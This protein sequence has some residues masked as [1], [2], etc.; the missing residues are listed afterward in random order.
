MQTENGAT[1]V[2]GTTTK[3]PIKFWTDEEGFAISCIDR[4]IREQGSPKKVVRTMDISEADV[5]YMDSEDKHFRDTHS[6]APEMIGERVRGILA[7]PPRQDHL[8][9]S[10]DGR[11][12]AAH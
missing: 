8:T 6:K 2:N 5:T 12:L 11:S 3:A 4:A 7:P 9:L 10:L 1:Q